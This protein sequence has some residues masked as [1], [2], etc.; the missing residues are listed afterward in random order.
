LRHTAY[1]MVNHPADILCDACG[2]ACGWLLLAPDG[3]E[4]GQ[5]KDGTARDVLL[6]PHVHHRLIQQAAFN[7]RAACGKSIKRG[8]GGNR[9]SAEPLERQV[10]DHLLEIYVTLTAQVPRVS[11]FMFQDRI[12]GPA[13]EFLR[14]VLREVGL[15][16]PSGS[17]LARWISAFRLRHKKWSPA[18]SGLR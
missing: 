8:K 15:S 14:V 10:V 13:V 1:G 3:R 17:S 2:W 18:R 11:N 4:V 16:A 5:I 9:R 7:A 6:H 12:G